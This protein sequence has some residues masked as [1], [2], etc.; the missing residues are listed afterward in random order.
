MGNLW[1]LKS[2]LDRWLGWDPKNVFG[3]RRL[4]G[5][6]ILERLREMEDRRMPLGEL[7]HR[8]GTMG[9]LPADTGQATAAG[10]TT[11]DAF[12]D[13]VMAAIRTAMPGVRQEVSRLLDGIVVSPTVRITPRING[14]D[15]RGIHA[16]V[17]VG[18]GHR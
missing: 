7:Q 12:A 5:D 3:E 9:E 1:G 13:A 10:Q 2:G 4:S 15:L 14:G 8:I 11:G 6:A 16:D 17:G 18:P